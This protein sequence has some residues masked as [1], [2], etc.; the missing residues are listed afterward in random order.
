MDGEGGV[1]LLQAP[2]LPSGVDVDGDHERGRWKVASV[3][4]LRL[5]VVHLVEW[6]IGLKVQT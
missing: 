2:Q 5:I 4:G 3:K 6:R 1:V